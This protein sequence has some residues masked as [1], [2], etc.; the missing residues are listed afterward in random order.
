MAK[1]QSSRRVP[2]LGVALTLGLTLAFASCVFQTQPQD[3]SQGSAFSL[4]FQDPQS[5]FAFDS[6]LLILGDS[7]ETQGAAHRDTLFHGRAQIASDLRMLRPRS[8]G[9]ALRD[10]EDFRQH[11]LNDSGVT[12]LTLEGYQDS[13]RTYFQRLSIEVG[14]KPVVISH[15]QLRLDRFEYVG[16]PRF[17]SGLADR[18]QLVVDAS[19][20]PYVAYADASQGYRALVMRL[21]AAQGGWDRVGHGPISEGSAGQLDMIVAKSGEIVVAFND[22][23]DLPKLKVLCMRHTGETWEALA[24]T[25]LPIA[26]TS[27]LDLA[28]GPDGQP[29]LAYKEEDS[30]W[31]ASVARF[32]PNLQKWIQVGQAAFS[33]GPVNFL[34]LDVSPRGVAYVAFYDENLNGRATVMRCAPETQTWEKVGLAGF[35]EIKTGETTIRI[36]AD[37]TPY[38]AFIDGSVEDKPARVMRFRESVWQPFISERASPGAAYQIDLF[39]D[40]QNQAL[41]A[42]SDAQNA[43]GITVMSANEIKG[44]WNV[45]GAAGT[46]AG[47]AVAISLALDNQD[48]P[49][50]AFAE[51]QASKLSVM[52][53]LQE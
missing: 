5:L 3:P 9:N 20:R 35:T 11:A 46:S 43:A 34:S 47:R 16:L 25:S 13:A 12:W 21:N 15:T 44:R 24:P 1:P 10:A 28:V 29:Y 7:S 33:D 8:S 45:L 37:E 51:G 41:L 50:V 30:E 42:F 48:R 19:G 14:N 38:L 32:D 53:W 18:P 22:Y 6:L 40:S 4:S 23:T 49:W 36:A 31:K 26:W 27:Q 52:R 17:S 39:F 2:K